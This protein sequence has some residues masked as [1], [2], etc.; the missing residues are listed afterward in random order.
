MSRPSRPK[1]PL[2][3]SG[4]GGEDHLDYRGPVI[5]VHTHPYLPGLPSVR[6]KSH[7]PADYLREARGI[8]LRAAAALVMAPRSDLAATRRMN[9]RVLALGKTRSGV[10]YPVCSVHPLDGADALAEIDRV[11]AAGARGLKLHPN[12]QQFDVADPGVAAVVAKASE[13]ELP[14]LFDAYSPFDAD[15]P[16]KFVMLA[17]GAPKAK[18]ILAHAHGPRFPDLLVYE[19]LARYDWWRRNVWIDLSA[20][21]PLLADSPFAAQFEWVLRK[22]GVDRLLYGSDYPLCEPTSAVA[23]IS[24]LRFSPSELRRIFYANAA[25]L[26]NITT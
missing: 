16:G 5:D 12:T 21:G 24:R 6:K 15:Q 19:I 1:T 26:Y 14:V 23:A 7:R 20:T 4:P 2:G 22:V 13:L 25:A 17:M 8:D 3:G 11:A 9:D 10:F 18:L